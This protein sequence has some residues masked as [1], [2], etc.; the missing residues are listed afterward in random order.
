MLHGNMH[1]LRTV[2][3]EK[4]QLTGFCM[5]NEGLICSLFA[6]ET[7]NHRCFMLKHFPTIQ[8]SSSIISSKTSAIQIYLCIISS[9]KCGEILSKEINWIEIM[10]CRCHV[11]IIRLCRALWLIIII[12]LVPLAFA[13]L[14]VRLD[15]L[16]LLWLLF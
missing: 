9:M 15:L 2:M 1:F 3:Y 5:W 7:H 16:S 12:L 10:I 8:I 4:K 13:F 11:C 14:V 6:P